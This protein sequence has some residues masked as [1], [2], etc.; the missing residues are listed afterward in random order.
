MRN[1][2]L[3]TDLSLFAGM[4][5]SISG[6]LWNYMPS[7]QCRLHYS[8]AFFEYALQRVK[9]EGISGDLKLLLTRAITDF[10]ATKEQIQILAALMN[11]DGLGEL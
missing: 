6:Y 2:S 8:S 1:L 3:E 5:G 7:E 11:S 4:L 10:A 9:E